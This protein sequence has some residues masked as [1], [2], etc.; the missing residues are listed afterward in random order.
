MK[1]L[2]HRILPD[3]KPALV[4]FMRIDPENVA[5]TL[6]DILTGLMDMSWLKNFDEDY[7][8]NAFRVRAE[9]TISDIKEKFEKGCND[10]ITSDAGEYVVSVLAKNALV[11]ELKYL[12]IP[13]AE[14]LGKKKSGNPGFDFHTQNN[15]SDTIIFGEAKY[16]AQH[17]AYSTALSQIVK[18]IDDKKDIKDLPD[19]KPFCSTNAL[20]RAN[21]GN[22]GF[23]AAFASKS[24]SSEALLANILSRSDYQ[25]L[26]KYEEL[27]L[28]AVNI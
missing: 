22:K 24:T 25:A 6:A 8:K 26:L 20:K 15:I 1:I 23:A 5:L 14:L 9:D 27:I 3:Q 10:E 18:F 2:E 28:L 4:R 7:E 16:I 19:L 21:G 17:S 12:E 11:N 13:L